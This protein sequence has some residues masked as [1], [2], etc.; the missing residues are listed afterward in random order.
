M[1]QSNDGAEAHAQHKHLQLQAQLIHIYA[2]IY[3]IVVLQIQKHEVG[4]S[5][6]SLKQGFTFSFILVEWKEYTYEL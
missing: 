5:R 2:F 3:Y 1:D 6:D 4:T